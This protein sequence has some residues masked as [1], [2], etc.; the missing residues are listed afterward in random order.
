[1]PQPSKL[2]RGGG[3]NGASTAAVV[4]SSF[5]VTFSYYFDIAITLLMTGF[6]FVWARSL[7]AQDAEPPTYPYFVE[8]VLREGF[9]NKEF[10]DPTKSTQ[11]ICFYTD[12]FMV[13]VSYLAARSRGLEKRNRFIFGAIYTLF[14]GLVHFSVEAL[15]GLST[16]PIETATLPLGPCHELCPSHHQDKLRRF[17][18][19]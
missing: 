11:M 14:H 8:R 1:M 15:P 9:C 5:E 7:K 12:F 17:S 13:G 2:S 18:Q 4:K 10:T 3:D 16:G 19:N 6:I